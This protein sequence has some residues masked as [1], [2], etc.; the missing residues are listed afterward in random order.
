MSDWDSLRAEI[1]GVFADGT[2]PEEV[3]AKVFHDLNVKME[4]IDEIIHKYVVFSKHKYS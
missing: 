2:L 3:K 1:E 4:K